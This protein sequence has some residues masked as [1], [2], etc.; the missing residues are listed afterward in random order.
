MTAVVG[1]RTTALDRA[2]RRWRRVRWTLLVLA[3]FAL[4]VAVLAVA[5]PTT[6]TAAYSP[7]SVAP[8]GSRALAQVLRRQGVDVRH[9]TTVDEAVRAAAPG[10]TLLV[11]P[12]P[13]LTTEQAEAIAQVPA[14]VVLVAPGGTL[15][16][17]ATD[18]TVGLS[19]QADGG[20][21][22]PGCDD[23]AAQAA[24]TVRL[25]APLLVLDETVT[26]CY[27]AG[28][29]VGLA[30]LDASRTGRGNV[31]AVGDPALL[32]NDSVTAQGN[33]ALALRLLGANERLVWFVP[34]PFDTTTGE[35]VSAQG[36]VLPRWAGVIALWA[37]LCAVVAAAW[38]A[39]R[40]GPLVAEDLP[41]VVPAAETTRGRGRLYR[42]ARAR[43]HA[44]AALRAAAADRM[45][46]RLGVSRGAGATTLVDAVAQAST[47]DPHEVRDLMY[48]P[49]PADDA[50]LAALARRLDDLESEVH[51]Q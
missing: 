19:V 45:A 13:L 29:G 3:L 14:D 41:V 38:R 43:G 24:G 10:T 12:A 39:R 18:G 36:G 28:D 42:R 15:L 20:D 23:P 37:L 7:D 16:D 35:G 17:L 27:P 30:H 4:V 49:P 21:L 47:R 31:T 50:A 33:A 46:G 48:G 25:Y 51:R 11:A 26:A 2:G 22:A 9:V 34:D 40:L 1:D 5:R 6:T 8:D 44:A 32:R